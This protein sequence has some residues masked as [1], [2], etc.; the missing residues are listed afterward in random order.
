MPCAGF[1][2][3]HTLRTPPHTSLRT[4]PAPCY[5]PNWVWFAMQMGKC[6]GGPCGWSSFML[7][8]GRGACLR[9]WV[10]KWEEAMTQGMICSSRKG[11]HH[12]CVPALRAILRVRPVDG[13]P[14][15]SVV[16]GARVCGCGSGNGKKPWQRLHRVPSCMC[17]WMRTHPCV[18]MGGLCGH[19]GGVRRRWRRTGGPRGCGDTLVGHAD[20]GAVGRVNVQMRGWAMQTCGRWSGWRVGAPAEGARSNGR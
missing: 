6:V 8:G 15:C 3:L 20:V 13:R 16:E 4:P 19:V 2:P 17:V 9:L 10:W 12:A 1:V 14:S 18:D 11:R 7:S 5:M